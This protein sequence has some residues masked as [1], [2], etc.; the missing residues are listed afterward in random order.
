MQALSVFRK[1]SICCLLI[2]FTAVSILAGEGGLTK[3]IIKKS[4]EAYKLDIPTRASYNAVTNND[5]RDLALNRDI[6]RN[7]N[8]LFSHK[9]KTKGIVDQ[10][11]SGRCWVFAW[12][13][14]MRPMVIEKHDLDKFEFSQNYLT[15]WDKME[16]ANRFLEYIIE[17]R[18]RDLE[19]R[20]LTLILESPFSDGG[21]WRYA[22]NLIKKYGLVP[23]EIMPETNSSENTRLMNR[24]ISKKLRMDAAQ[25][26]KMFQNGASVKELRKFKEDKLIEVYRLL[27]MNIGEP[28]VEFEWRYQIDDTTLS[29]DK[30]YTPLSFFK[31]FVGAE[32]DDFVCLYNNPTR[33]YGERY[34][35]SMSRNLYDGEDFDHVN[36]EIE[37]L[38]E[39]AKASILDNQPL[40]FSSDVG[41]DQNSDLGMMA[42]NLYDYG[43]LFGIDLD[44]SKE[45]MA[46]YLHSSSNHGM[47]LIGVDIIDGKPVKWLVE[48]S[49]GDE[50][51]SDGLWTMYDDWFDNYVFYIIA[52]KKYVPRNI[53]KLF[54]KD[55][56]IIPPWDPIASFI[57]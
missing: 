14:T 45:D 29:D 31:K 40:Y 28:P 17:F 1:I 11:S 27:A 19:D 38:K 34:I 36:V 7:H 2:L 49:W 26:R 5:I 23:K 35:S 12:L 51:G 9:I 46:L 13:N 44:M 48:N 57:K 53:L 24:V 8:E 43:T 32:L 39:I 54:D 18:E 10:K 56:I 16:K 22:V 3:S 41:K 37:R 21:Y 55:P 33:A 25:I 20:E 50:K 47:S 30:T 52:R 42:E 4:R 15:F 6:V